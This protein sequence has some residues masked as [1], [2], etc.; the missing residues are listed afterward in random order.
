VGGVSELPGAAL[1]GFALAAS[2]GPVNAL[3][4]VRGL[5]HGASQAVLLALGADTAD[6]LYATLVILGVGPFVN[7]PAIQVVLSIGGGLFLA[8]L[9][10]ANLRAA[11]RPNTDASVER[12]AGASWLAAYREGFMIAL[13]SPLTIV[14]WTSVFGGYYAEVIARGSRTPPALLLTV[15]MLGAGVWTGIAALF[16]HFGRRARAGRWYPVFVTLLSI[17]LL[18]YAARLLSSGAQ[19]VGAQFG[20]RRSAATP[21]RLA[22]APLVTS[23]Q[24]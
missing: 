15:L 4:F 22:L 14:F 9:G 3:G 10:L 7:R 20:P 21:L 2:P 5:R 6:I 8:H 1:L 24:P 11:W 19:T 13:L 23:Q 17:L 16:V 12:P 18:A